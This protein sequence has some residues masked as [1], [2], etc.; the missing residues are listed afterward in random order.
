MYNTSVKAKEKNSMGTFKVSITAEDSSDS[1]STGLVVQ[2]A[3]T[4]DSTI[5][6]KWIVDFGA[7]YLSH[8]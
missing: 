4:A 7:T 3:L 6:K 2:H 1:E 8:V 5:P